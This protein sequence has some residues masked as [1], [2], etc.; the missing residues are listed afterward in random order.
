M[1]TQINKDQLRQPSG[2]TAP[3]DE[4]FYAILGSNNGAN[5]M[6]LLIDHKYELGRI[7]KGGHLLQSQM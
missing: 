1:T 3:L 2:Y 5:L 7:A 4:G 6:R